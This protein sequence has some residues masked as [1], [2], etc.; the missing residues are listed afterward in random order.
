[1]TDDLDPP[2]NGE[3]NDLTADP[4]ASEPLVPPDPDVTE[5]F[6]AIPEDDTAAEAEATGAGGDESP[7]DDY[8][9]KNDTTD[10]VEDDG[11]EVDTAVGPLDADSDD[12]WTPSRRGNRDRRTL[13]RCIG[14]CRRCRNER[15]GGG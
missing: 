6:T 7:I 5:E 9:P 10:A 1:M 12:D 3:S 8:T 4:W 13:R 14:S 11:S 15:G 2:E